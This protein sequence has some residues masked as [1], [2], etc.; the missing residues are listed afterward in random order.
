M[1]I[2]GFGLN[3]INV[4]RK[5]PV[6]GQVNISNNV[7]I[8]SVEETDLSVGSHKQ[9]GVK[10]LFEFTSKYEPGIAEMIM[11]GE[12]LYM[13]EPKKNKELLSEWKKNRSVPKEIMTDVLNSILMRCN[14][15][16][17]LLARDI[18]LPPPV[19]L[20]RIQ[21]EQASSEYIG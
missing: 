3:K 7:S 15:E 17:L 21:E 13:G 20:P 2:V 10:F 11:A 5:A 19:Q 8:K 16:A 14:V 1:T 9:E 4:E 6:K 18:N 12:V